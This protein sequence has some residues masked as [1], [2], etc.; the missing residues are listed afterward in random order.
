MSLKRPVPNHRNVGER[1][2]AV[3]LPIGERPLVTGILNVTPDS[4]SDGGRFDSVDKAVKQAFL[5]ASQGADIID[6]GGEST[7]PGANP[8]SIDEELERVLPVI[9]VLQGKIDIPISIDTRKSEVA[10]EAC[11]AGATIINDVSGLRNDK[12]IAEVAREYSTYLVLMHM[13]KTP[14]TMQIEIHYDDLIGEISDFLLKA[15]DKALEVGVPKNRIIIDPGIGFGKTVEHNFSILKNIATF[16]NLGFPVLIGVSRKS[17]IGKT[18]DLPVDERL[19]GSLAAALY[20]VLNGASIIRVHDVLPTI[21][22][23]KIIEII[24]GA[25]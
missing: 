20:A 15:I 21:R 25:D 14:E 23:L 17:F 9:E 6:I 5:M 11:R 12:R 16:K 24:N 18:L 7:R 19:E 3:V 1:K 8:V 2:E 10:R 4:F 13:R 22:A